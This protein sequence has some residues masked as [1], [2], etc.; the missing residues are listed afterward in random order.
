MSEPS[1][2]TVKWKEGHLVLLDQTKLPLQV[3]YIHLTNVNQV[4]QSIRNLVVRGAN[5]IGITA[6]YGLYLGLRE[7]KAYTKEA[8]LQEFEAVASYLETARPTAVHMFWAIHRVREVLLNFQPSLSED[9]ASSVAAS[10]LEIVLAEGQK[11]QKDDIERCQA[12]GNYGLTLMHDGM[13]ILTH[14]NAGALGTTQYGT[15]LAPMYLAKEK[16]W[17]IR[18]FADETRPVLQGARLTAWELSQ[19]GID[20]TLIC[21]NMAAGVMGKGWIDIVFVGA[22]RIAANGDT[23]NKIG[24]YGVAILAKEHGIP[25][26]VAA[27][28]STIDSKTPTGK[29][30]VIEERPAE[31]IT[32]GLGRRIAPIDIKVYNPAFDVT[33]NELISG[34]ITEKGI[35]RAPY[36]ENIHKLIMG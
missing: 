28:T 30:I 34:I 1:F 7:T 13:G 9:S 10:L 8:F 25:F 17:D 21:D 19:A 6:A 12:I 24:T 14:C 16:G 29:N 33:P 31:E 23:A 18:V 27:P 32:E 11:I 3:E 26:Y 4:W 36:G 20:V 5:A 2:Q 22:D 15:A 35:I